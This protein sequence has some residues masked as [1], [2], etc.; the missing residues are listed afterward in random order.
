MPMKSL[1]SILAGCVLAVFAQ[2]PASAQAD[3]YKGKTVTIVVGTRIGG[4]IGNTAL[5]VSRH[6]GKYIPGNPTVILRQMPGG[7]HLNATNH[8]FNVADA[9][10]LTILASNPAVALAQL[11]KL[12]AV[13]FDVQKFHW[14]GSTG[15]DGTLFAIRSTLPYKSFKELQT[16]KQDII[17]GTTGPGSNAHDGP[18]LLKEF[19]GAKFKLLAGFQAN[20]DIRLALE[21]GEADGWSALSTT[22]RQAAALGTV[23]PLV[24]GRSPVKGF[25][26]LPVDENLMPPGLGRSLMVIRG[27]PPAIGRPF[28]VR[29]GTPLDRVAMLR[30]AFAKVMR[31]PAYQAEMEKAQIDID[32]L[33]AEHVTKDFAAMMNQPAEAVAAMAKYFKTEGGG[34]G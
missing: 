9:D 21:R 2:A 8:V 23:R 3:F 11:T 16:L 29:H 4:S 6:L 14:L 24:R 18:L 25:E 31:D 20:G 12:K 5:I 15:P 27:T 34:G 13:R 17:V 22:I 28:G 19:A 30:D 7:A 1:A 10:G 26:H 32:P 33:S